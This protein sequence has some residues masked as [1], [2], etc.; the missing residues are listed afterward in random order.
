MQG[1]HQKAWLKR[2]T[3]CRI[4][5]LGRAVAQSGSASVSGSEGRKFE[6]CQPDQ[7]NLYPF[8]HTSLDRKI[9]DADKGLFVVG[10]GNLGQSCNCRIGSFLSAHR[11]VLERTG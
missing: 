1:Q 11:R 5:H 6:S 7:L 4:L 9:G 10:V 3:C 8:L 2:Q